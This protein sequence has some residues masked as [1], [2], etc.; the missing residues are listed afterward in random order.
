MWTKDWDRRLLEFLQRHAYLS[1]TCPFTLGVNGDDKRFSL[2]D[3]ARVVDSLLQTQTIQHADVKLNITPQIDC[4]HLRI[5]GASIISVSENG[6]PPL[7]G[8]MSIAYNNVLAELEYE[9]HTELELLPDS[10]NDF[11]NIDEFTPQI[12][13]I[14][15]LIGDQPKYINY[16]SL[17]SRIDSFNVNSWRQLTISQTESPLLKTESFAI[18]GFYYTGTSDLVKCFWCG[19]TLNNLEV[20]D[21]PL[22]KH[23]RNFPRCT[24][25]LRLLGRHQ[26]KYIY[27]K[28]DDAQTGGIATAQHIKPIDYTFIK[29][30]EDI[31]GMW[32]YR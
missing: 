21:D 16:I 10:E 19:L 14:D 5:R 6:I 1:A 26:V 20:D 22:T 4:R 12:T 15:Y 28:A 3:I 7:D 25:L 9:L 2:D 29:D 11:S 31:A 18:A 13:P 30:V 8:D 17:Q 24:W 32:C 27:M 23:V